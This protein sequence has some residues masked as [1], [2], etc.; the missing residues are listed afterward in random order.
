M[1]WWRERHPEWHN[2]ASWMVGVESLWLG[3]VSFRMGLGDRAS[4]YYDDTSFGF[5]LRTTTMDGRLRLAADYATVNMKDIPDV[6][7]LHFPETLT[8][9]SLTATWTP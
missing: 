9:Y 5:G 6:P 2:D 1:D 4:D 3:T 8:V 7:I